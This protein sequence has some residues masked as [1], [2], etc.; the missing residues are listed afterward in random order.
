MK[1][2][3]KSV[4]VLTIAFGAVAFTNT[5]KKV[6]IVE[7]SIEW[8]GKKVLGSHTG[9]IQLKEGHLEM[10]GNELTGGMF[11]VDMTTINVTD[12]KVGD[13]KEKLEGHL[14][15]EDFFGVEAHPT[16]T[17]VFTSVQ[18]MSGAY[19]I[20]GNMTIK[21]TTSPIAFNLEMDGNTATTKLNIDRSKYNVRYGSGSFFDSLGDN[22]I[23]DKF[24]L[25]I[26]L[27][28]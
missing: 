19:E 10:D 8:T 15:S 3:I 28:F 1:K 26:T 20:E 21:E 12:L 16:A 25:N 27:K 13:G 5:I 14:K 2:I 18:K 22:T 7:S 24:E 23:S 9:T 4:L 17:L 11:V 6:D